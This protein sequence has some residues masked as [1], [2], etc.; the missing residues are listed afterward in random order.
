MVVRVGPG[1][2]DVFGATAQ[3]GRLLTAEEASP[4]G[5]PAVVISDAYWRRQFAADPGVIGTTL[6]LDQRTL[7]IVGVAAPAF[8]FPAR[9]DLY[10]ADQGRLAT[11]VAHRTQLPRGGP[12]RRRA[13]RW[14]RPKPR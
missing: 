1:Y 7:S 4:D 2:F 9:A 13:R 12:P 11:D 8:R 5:P 14:R 6:T 10:A 3:L